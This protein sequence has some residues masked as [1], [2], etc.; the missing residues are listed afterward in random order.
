MANNGKIAFCDWQDCKRCKNHYGDRHCQFKDSIK[1]NIRM[2]G[3]L[4][5][6]GLFKEIEK[7]D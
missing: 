4:I 1:Y 7:Q 6:C 3:D 2:E 5:R